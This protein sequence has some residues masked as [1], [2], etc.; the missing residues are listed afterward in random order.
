MSAAFVDGVLI[1]ELPDLDGEQSQHGPQR[2]SAAARV[3]VAGGAAA[4][5][6]TDNS[7]PDQLVD[8]DIA[9]HANVAG[10]GEL[11]LA[12]GG[13]AAEP[14]TQVQQ[15]VRVPA[16]I[17]SRQSQTFFFGMLVLPWLRHLP[18]PWRWCEGCVQDAGRGPNEGLAQDEPQLTRAVPRTSNPQEPDPDGTFPRYAVQ[19]STATTEKD[20]HLCY[21]WELLKSGVDFSGICMLLQEDGRPKHILQN[22]C[23]DTLST[24]GVQVAPVESGITGEG[25]FQLRLGKVPQDVFACIFAVAAVATEQL[26]P[27]RKAAAFG[28]VSSSYVALRNAGAKKEE[29]HIWRFTQP[30]A[31]EIANVWVC[32]AL[33]RGPGCRWRLEPFSRRFVAM[34]VARGED[35]RDGIIRTAEGVAWQT[36]WFVRDRS[37]AVAS[38]ERCI[39]GGDTH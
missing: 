1:E 27:K 35:L 9:Q 38:E 37:W 5:V 10:I 39:V 22:G 24:L 20:L 21:G 14:I 2:S 13:G 7:I 18:G 29:K 15:Q 30:T 28:F 16:L 8:A 31:H 3:W 6:E 26:D 36:K 17:D 34:A 12:R 23:G 25:C 11:S 32:A 33:Y 19:I 4:A